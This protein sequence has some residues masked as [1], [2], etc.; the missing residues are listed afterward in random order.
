MRWT[1][2]TLRRCPNWTLRTR[3]HLALRPFLEAPP[4]PSAHGR[5]LAARSFLAGTVCRAS[6]SPIPVDRSKSLRCKATQTGSLRPGRSSPS[7]IRVPVEGNRHP[8]RQSLPN[9]PSIAERRVRKN[10]STSIVGTPC[11]DAVRLSMPQRCRT[12]PAPRATL[13][14]S[15]AESRAR[16]SMPIAPWQSREQ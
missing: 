6:S 5:P 3:A 10:E 15:L 14:E 2:A 12:E 4:D 7:H 1:P 13:E 9:R 11:D 8:I 16:R